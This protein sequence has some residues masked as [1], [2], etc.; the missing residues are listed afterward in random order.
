MVALAEVPMSTGVDTEQESDSWTAREIQEA[1]ALCRAAAADQARWALADWL[2]ERCP[3]ST[4]GVNTGTYR[5]IDELA[6]VVGWSG[7]RLRELRATAWAWPAPTRLPDDAGFDTHSAFRRGGPAQADAR[8]E[9]LLALPRNRA[10]RVS[11]TAVRTL[12][13][14]RANVPQSPEPRAPR[15]RSQAVAD[16]AASA[17][18]A[19][20]LR[21][22]DR[23]LTRADELMRSDALSSETRHALDHLVGAIEVVAAALAGNHA[24]PPPRPDRPM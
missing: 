5:R 15:S 19:E 11:H 3:W 12:R 8:R 21:D 10:G 24:A 2:L 17:P 13:R 14:R 23:L 1:A 6:D 4:S 16:S 9:Q 7:E 20:L 18:V 22:C